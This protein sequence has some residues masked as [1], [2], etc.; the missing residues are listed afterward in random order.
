MFF[1]DYTIRVIN[2][3]SR[4]IN[5][6]FFK[7][8][9][10]KLLLNKKGSAILCYHGIDLHG[11]K[12]LNMRF[13]SK[14]SLENHFI[15]FKKHFNVISVQ[16][17]F[18]GKFDDNKFNLA[19]TFDD[20]YKNNF[21]YLIPLAEKYRV[22]VSIFV[23]GI[24]NTPYNFLWADFIDIVSKYSKLQKIE[25]DNILFVKKRNIYTNSDNISIQKLIKEK[26]DWNFKET[27]FRALINEFN[28]ITKKHNLDDYWQL[29]NDDEIKKASKS[30]FITIGSHGY[31]HNNMDKIPISLAEEELLNSK[32]YL[33]NLTQQPISEIAYPDGAYSREIIKVC[34]DLGITKQLALNYMHSEDKTDFRIINRHGIYP[35]Y[36][37]YYQISNIPNLL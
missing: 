7:L 34:S 9:I 33:E 4:I 23:T 28:M 29:M 36:S 2:K 8:G 17:Y 16:D 30:D 22:P 1:K 19:I 37:D 24:N 20:G 6:S 15:Y 31:F 3:S 26:G 18:L 21:K 35:V 10:E 25:I 32:K 13:F 27:L 11:N 12:Q 14:N 5:D